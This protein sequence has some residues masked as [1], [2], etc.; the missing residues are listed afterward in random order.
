MAVPSAAVSTDV[1]A[2]YWFLFAIDAIDAADCKDADCKVADCKAALRACSAADSTTDY[3]LTRIFPTKG[4]SNRVDWCVTN[5]LILPEFL[6]L[7]FTACG[8]ILKLSASFVWRTTTIMR[9]RSNI[10][11]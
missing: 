6:S 3:R 2:T 9:Q 11:N 8:F 4:A 10:P 7:V 1:V 5:F